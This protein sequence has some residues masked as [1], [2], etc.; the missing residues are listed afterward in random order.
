MAV[1]LPA[2][3]HPSPE[4][5]LKTPDSALKCGELTAIWSDASVSPR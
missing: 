1:S 4:P 5:R 3:R 2:S